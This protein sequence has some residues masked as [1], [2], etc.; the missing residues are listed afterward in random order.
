MQFW[1]CDFVEAGPI[2][3]LRLVGWLVSWLVGYQFFSKTALRIFLIFCM[4]VPYY[5]GKKRTRR[6]FREKSGSF[7]NDEYVY[8]S[9][10]SILVM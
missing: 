10:P 6:F 9:V 2:E 5:K 7:N 8:F 4:K 3:S 1:T